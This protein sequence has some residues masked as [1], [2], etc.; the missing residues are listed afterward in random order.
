MSARDRAPKKWARAL[1][2]FI[3]TVECI[4]QHLACV[5]MHKQAFNVKRKARKRKQRFGRKFGCGRDQAGSYLII[6]SERNSEQQSIFGAEYKYRGG[7]RAGGVKQQ[8]NEQRQE[9]RRNSVE[10][11]RSTTEN[12][13]EDRY[14]P[15]NCRFMR[16][17]ER[18]EI[19]SN[20]RVVPKHGHCPLGQQQHVLAVDEVIEAVEELSVGY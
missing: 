7:T 11:Y 18:R 10:S 1:F 3:S 4:V 15:I 19:L 16:R 20:Q 6:K 2:V 13:A 8:K 5:Y 12:T 9:K 14:M 17:N